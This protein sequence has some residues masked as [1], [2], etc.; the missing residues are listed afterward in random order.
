M[1]TFESSSSY[2][3]FGSLSA[4]G[5]TRNN[6]P[7]RRGVVD[8]G[9]TNVAN[10]GVNQGG[11]SNVS[12]LLKASV[13]S[14]AYLGQLATANQVGPF[15]T[16]NRNPTAQNS[17]MQFHDPSPALNERSVRAAVLEQ[18]PS[19]SSSFDNIMNQPPDVQRLL[20]GMLEQSILRQGESSTS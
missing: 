14:P 1:R 20:L 12:Q 9:I 8:F 2:N 5:N 17:E 19:L 6:A 18:N 4:T 10:D 16:I 11:S 15:P 7:S 13:T 3:L